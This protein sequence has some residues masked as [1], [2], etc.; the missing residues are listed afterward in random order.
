MLLNYTNG[1]RNEKS[2]AT[3]VN[4]KINNINCKV[5]VDSGAEST[6]VDKKVANKLHLKIFEDD[7]NIDYIT[8]NGDSLKKSGWSL[9]EMMIGSYKFRQNVL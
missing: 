7:S 2:S 3:F 9:I 6:L 8:A 5:I 4:L 1:P